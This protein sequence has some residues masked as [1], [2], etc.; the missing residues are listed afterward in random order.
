VGWAATQ[1]G[2]RGGTREGEV[3]EK[4]QSN[5]F[6]FQKEYKSGRRGQEGY[7]AYTSRDYSPDE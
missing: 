5:G 1:A 6:V 7:G 4:E 2:H 3:S